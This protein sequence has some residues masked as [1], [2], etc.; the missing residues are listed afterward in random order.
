[1]TDTVIDLI[2]HGEP[3]GGHKYRGQIDDPLSEKGWKQMR[4]K[5]AGHTPWQQLCSSPLLRCSAFAEE[6]SSRHQLPLAFDDRLKEVGFGVWE[7]RTRSQLN[8]ED[9]E[10]IKR[11]RADP[12][13]SRP[14]GAEP[15]Q[16]FSQRVNDAV[17]EIAAS[18]RQKHVLIVCHAGV[19]RM[20]LA[21]VL[22]I[23]LI[24]TYHI[25]VAT[26]AL[27]RI[28]IDDNGNRRLVFHDGRAG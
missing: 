26:A 20:T 23:P 2:R 16:A 1:M 17:D 22:N 25:E 19:I 14:P 4:D 11:F 24:N 27:S 8:E 6:L 9:P 15:L 18:H 7:G 3:V 21:H 28:A 5:V 13:N 10:Q 12:I